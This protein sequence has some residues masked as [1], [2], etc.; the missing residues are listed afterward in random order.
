[1]PIRI[2]FF[3]AFSVLVGLACA[4][5]FFGIRG[6]AASGDLVLRLNDGPLTGINHARLAQAKLNEARLLIAA[7]PGN[8]VRVETELKFGA[9]VTA[10]A[11]DLS[12][13]RERIKN[14]DVRAALAVAEER[15]RDWSQ[16]AYEFLSERPDGLAMP[17]AGSPIRRKSSDAVAVYGFSY[18]MEAEARVADARATLLALTIGTCFVG[19]ML[20]VGFSY[21]MGRP[22]LEAMQVAERVAAGNLSDVI[23]S[24]RHDE[25]GRLLRSLA[26]M[27]SHLK[28]RADA[29]GAM[30]EKLDVALNSMRKGLVMFGPDRRLMLWNARYAS[31]YRIPAERLRVGCT[32]DDLLEERRMAGTANLNVAQYDAKMKTAIQTNS[33]D[34]MVGELIDGRT[35]KIECQPTAKGSYIVT[36]E[37][38]TERTQNEAR[39]THLA[40]HDPLTDLPNRAAFSDHIARTLRNAALNDSFAILCIDLDRFKEINDV[41]GH[42]AGD[43]F[44]I[45]VGFRLEMACNG[46]FLARLGG[47]EFTIVSTGGPQPDTAEQLC[48]RLSSV[49]DTPI[50]IQDMDIAG[51]FTV[52]VSLYPQDGSEID[53]LV[54]N[55]EAALHRAKVQERGTI[56]FF[57]PAM[58]QQIREKRSLHQDVAHALEK[59]EFELFYQ[60]QATV[61]GDIFGFEVLLRWRHPVR[62]MVSPGLFIPLAEE[63]GAI[64][65]I[66]KWVLREACREAASWPNPLSIAVNLSPVDFRHGDVPEMILSALLDTGLSPHRLEI[67]ITEGVL[68]EDFDRAIDTLRKIKNLGV[69][70]AMDDFGSGYSSLS[71]LQS[72]PFDKIKIDQS[73][74]AKIGK[75]YPA[76]AIIHAIVGLGRSLQLPVIAEGVETPEQLAFLA[77][78]GCDEVQGY[79]IGRPE[80]IARYQHVIGNPAAISE[81]AALAG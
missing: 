31:M 56:R 13:V 19:I 76:G 44:L 26:A 63:S 34:S 35:V 38:I 18:R 20:A 74:I 77:K 24:S 14:D 30:M 29:D 49:F 15:F 59:N 66:D 8:D 4:L 37:D 17:P 10:I 73:F 1:M 48:E 61:G 39:I 52:G 58:D 42:S 75:N 47:D 79:L 69:R 70:V 41:Y 40:F 22:I 53:T 64:G 68:I 36:H 81:V 46:A 57:E 62:G 21:S 67:E 11:E 43:Q 27:Q 60:P 78:E 5:A 55:A 2:K 7:N 32:L 28:T 23:G 54:A 33:H 51:S 12:V 72:F 6:I 65:P 9:I 71:Y 3:L 80:R 50:R 16:A 25:L 45:E